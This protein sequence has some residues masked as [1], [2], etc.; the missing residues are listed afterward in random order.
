MAKSAL[1]SGRLRLPPLRALF[2]TQKKK[3]I[4]PLRV[5]PRKRDLGRIMGTVLRSAIGE[6]FQTCIPIIESVNPSYRVGSS[7]NYTFYTQLTHFMPIVE[8]DLP[9]TNTPAAECEEFTFC[10][11]NVPSPHSSVY[12]CF[13]RVQ[14]F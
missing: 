14:V 2:T 11:R 8:F 10:N 12:N 1:L 5:A 7:S 4:L 13:Y 6:Y 3:R 9:G